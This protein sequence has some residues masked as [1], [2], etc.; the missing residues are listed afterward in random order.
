[1]KVLL[2]ANIIKNENLE[3]LSR[4]K[5]LKTFE[6]YLSIALL[7]QRF[8]PLAKFNK[9]EFE[10]WLRILF[11]ICEER[12]LDDFRCITMKEINPKRKKGHKYQFCS[13]AEMSK[14]KKNFLAG[15]F[16]H[17]I[18]DKIQDSKQASRDIVCESEALYKQKDFSTKERVRNEEQ[19]LIEF[20]TENNF[21]KLNE[22]KE[23]FSQA[24][25]LIDKMKIVCK[26]YTEVDFLQW[27]TNNQLSLQ[28]FYD[29][30]HK[31][32]YLDIFLKSYL[33]GALY[34][35]NNPNKKVDKDWHIDNGYIITMKDLDILLSNDTGY[36]KECFECVYGGNS[37]VNS[38][39]I[40]TLQE[41][42]DEFL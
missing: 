40:M 38:K 32:P 5:D 33:F 28:T 31:Y 42:T 10:T 4:F 2:D 1:M 41:F 11:D 20:L 18:F 24:N 13:I 8:V 22:V 26:Y 9:I 30:T 16:N 35:V 37:S 39:K 29:K 25:S 21:P 36:M 7:V 3:T 14:I 6:F 17:S 23:E 27:H 12:V 34:K 19:K 15:N